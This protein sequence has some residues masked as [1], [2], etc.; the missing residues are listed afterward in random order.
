MSEHRKRMD[1]CAATNFQF[2]INLT[3]YYAEPSFP[4][5]CSLQ[6]GNREVQ[7]N[8]LHQSSKTSS[9]REG[10]SKKQKR[11]TEGKFKKKKKK[12][13]TLCVKVA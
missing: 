13:Q 3:A 4:F 11:K 10:Q 9:E 6:I 2:S 12:S 8:S 1:A 7:L 5:T